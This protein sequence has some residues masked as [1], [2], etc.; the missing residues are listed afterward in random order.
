LEAYI[1]YVKI[2]RN[3]TASRKMKK[4]MREEGKE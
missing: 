3:S 1:P 2:G 4:L